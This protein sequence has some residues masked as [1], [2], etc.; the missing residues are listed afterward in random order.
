LNTSTPAA[1]PLAALSPGRAAAGLGITALLVTATLNW[2]HLA[3]WCLPLL[4]L[5]SALHYRATLRGQALPGR[6]ARLWLGKLNRGLESAT[7]RPRRH[8]AGGD[9]GREAV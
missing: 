7:T 8:A 6:L 3:W 4:V 2:Q 1:P 5:A 9:N